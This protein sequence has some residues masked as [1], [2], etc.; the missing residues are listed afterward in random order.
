MIQILQQVNERGIF[1]TRSISITFFTCRRHIYGVW[2]T[3]G[4]LEKKKPF[5]NLNINMWKD[6]YNSRFRKIDNRSATDSRRESQRR[7]KRIDIRRS[8]F[9]MRA[10]A[11]V[12]VWKRHQ[13]TAIIWPLVVV[14]AVAAAMI[15]GH[16][17][18]KINLANR[19]YPFIQNGPPAINIYISIHELQPLRH[20]RCVY[21]RLE[22]DWHSFSS[23]KVASTKCFRTMTD[24][25]SLNLFFCVQ[26]FGHS[27]KYSIW[28]LPFSS[29]WKSHVFPVSLSLSLAFSYVTKQSTQCISATL[30]YAIYRSKRNKNPCRLCIESYGKY[31]S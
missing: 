24:S 28:F 30:S 5:L 27:R 11:C 13:S 7:R 16:V 15:V 26:S 29:V 23:W 17:Y 25:F 1:Y 9:Q 3:T 21:M 4:A 12:K 22:C 2:S 31:L 20:F 19:P 18:T 6:D 10:C 8:T 14:V